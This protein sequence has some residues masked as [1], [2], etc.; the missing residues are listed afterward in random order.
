MLDGTHPPPPLSLPFR[1]EAYTSS[2]AR[3]F[4]AKPVALPAHGVLNYILSLQLPL[5]TLL[6]KKSHCSD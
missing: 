1:R 3:G 6:V 5:G 4:V 2:I